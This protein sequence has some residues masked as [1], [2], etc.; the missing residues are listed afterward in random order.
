MDATRRHRS[1]MSLKAWAGIALGIVTFAFGLTVF[2]EYVADAGSS[3]T[4]VAPTLRNAGTANWLTLPVDGG[5]ACWGPAA[6]GGCEKTLTL[7]NKCV[8]L[9]CNSAAGPVTHREGVTKA[10][11]T[12]RTNTLA[13]G[14]VGAVTPGHPLPQEG[15]EEFCLAPGVNSIG[16]RSE[17]PVDG[18]TPECELGILQ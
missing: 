2:T 3:I 11:V 5:S 8:R 4:Y 14:G 18:G 15:V 16:V 17:A 9:A 12:A 1:S 6:D 10:E 7:T 13:D